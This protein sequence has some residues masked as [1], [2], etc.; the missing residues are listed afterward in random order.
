MEEI[1]LEEKF[2]I[3]KVKWEKTLEEMGLD[4]IWKKMV[5]ITPFPGKTPMFAEV[6][7]VMPFTRNFF[8]EVG[9]NPELW[10]RLKYENFVE[11]S[12][13]VDR[14]VET[15]D[16]CMKEK[17]P[18][19]EIYWTKNLCYLSHPPAYLC[20]PDVGKSSC[21]A[22]YGKYATCE[23][24]HVDDF[25]REVYWVNGYHNEDGIPVHRWTV[26]ADENISK[27]FDAE[28]DVAF[29]QSTAEH[30]APASR[31]EL[32]ERLDRRHLRTG[33]KI[34]DA[35]KK[36]W[37]PYDW[38][39][40][41]RDVITDLRI[42]SFP[43]WVHATLYMSCVSMISSTIAQSVLTSSEFFIYVYYGLNTTALGINYNLFSYVPLP[44]MIRVL[45]GLPQET[46]VK[47]MSQL[48]LG[49]YD[50]FHRYTCKEKKIPNLFKLK[51]YTFEHG[52]FFPHYKGIP[53][54]M[55]I[56]RAI[57]P[58]LQKINLKQFLE[59]P[60]S[61]EFW[62]ILE[63]EARA[64]RETGEIP[65]AD[66]T[67]RM[68]FLLDPSIEPLKAKDFP[69]MDFNEGQIWPF[70]ITREKVEIMVEEG[71]DGSGRNI[72]YYSELANKKMGKK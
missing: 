14:A 55:V 36:H 31:K 45:I 63:S 69:P 38:G 48:F 68:Y 66:E 11:W 62:E 53:P 2:E 51:R 54:P 5:A 26:G 34:R 60:P 57:P 52:Q 44:P 16:R 18:K 67:G 49:G 37:D 12:Y 47:R 30:T 56:A 28:D 8:R 15:S 50:A 17:I 6:W 23:Y 10:Q 7:F 42:E 43:K 21:V 72:E 71:Y 9:I 20:R 65:P 41:V 35:P 32:D 13:R 40:A 64:N 59:T 61:K 3:E 22:L 33:I 1:G 24:V 25:T 27:Y 58:S 70:D 19:E 29:T 39:M 46:F 4:K